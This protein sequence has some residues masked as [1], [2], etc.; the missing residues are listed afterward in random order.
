[1]LVL[2]ELKKVRYPTWFKKTASEPL[3]VF[4]AGGGRSFARILEA[5]KEANRRFETAVYAEGIDLKEIPS[6]ETANGL[7][8]DMAG[9]LDVAYGLNFEKPDIGM[10]TPPGEIEDIPSRPRRE[11][12]QMISKDQV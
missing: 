11:P 12:R 1:M 7:P 6:V 8:A 9:R 2:M 3:S 4:M 5:M 10:I